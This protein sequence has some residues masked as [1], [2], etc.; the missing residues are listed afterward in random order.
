MATT[1]TS[2]TRNLSVA[3]AAG[4]GLIIVSSPWSGNSG[5][6]VLEGV[7]IAPGCGPYR[8][9]TE[10]VYLPSRSVQSKKSLLNKR[11]KLP[12]AEPAALL[13]TS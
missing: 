6:V 10:R 7:G 12:Q 13:H 2:A 5:W 8:F 3:P 9:R 4:V 11:V 1:A